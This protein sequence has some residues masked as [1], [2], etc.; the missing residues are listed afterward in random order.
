LDDELPS[1]NDIFDARYI[2]SYDYTSAHVAPSD[3]AGAALDLR[4][5]GPVQTVNKGRVHGAGAARH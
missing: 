5:A 2:F 3:S 4:H 1:A